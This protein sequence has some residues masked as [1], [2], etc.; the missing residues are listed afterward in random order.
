MNN[1]KTALITGITGQDGSY[2][3]ELLLHKGYKVHGLIRKASTFNT[4]RIDHIYQDPH[5]SAV[6]LFLHYGDLTDS[7]QI[8]N[9]I[10]NFKPDEIYHL[11]A[12]SHVRVSFDAPT[13][14]GSVT[15]LGTTRMLEAIRQSGATPSFYQASSSQD[16]GIGANQKSPGN[17][18][19]DNAAMGI[20]V[21]E[22]SRTAGVSKTVIVGTVC[23]YP[24]ITPVPFREDQIWE[25]YP[26]EAN[27]PYGLAKKMLLVQAQA[28][29]QQYGSNIIYL[30][31]TNLYGPA[32]NFDPESS[33]VIPALIRKFTE[34][35]DEDQRTVTVWGSGNATREFL[36]VDDAARGIVLAA[37]RFDGAEPVNLGAGKDISIGDLASLIKELVGYS[38]EIVFDTTMPDGHPRRRVDSSNASE[39]FGFESNVELRDGLMKSIE[40]FESQA[41]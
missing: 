18:F 20:H 17:F 32:D 30:I 23:S 9:L 37:E 22:E 39:Q 28:Y 25:G 38:G 4:A 24:K 26:E 14:T 8:T 7:E 40:W 16:C 13:Y 29:R 10:L 34:A 35:R 12:Q 6:N 21:I 27:A 3:A 5:G 2:L 33:H 41:A 11:G 15:G 19:Y 36:Y 31:P 1:K